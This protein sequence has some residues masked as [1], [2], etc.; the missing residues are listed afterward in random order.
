MKLLFNPSSVVVIGVSTRPF[1]LGQVIVW[2][3]FNFGFKGKIHLVGKESGSIMDHE[4]HAREGLQAF[5][6]KRA[7]QWQH[8]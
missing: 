6:A 1:N 4:I 3:L 5:L 2:N 8:K 7:P